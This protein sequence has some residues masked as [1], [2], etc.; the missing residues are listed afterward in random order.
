MLYPL[1]MLLIS[2]PSAYL[3]HACVNMVVPLKHLRLYSIAGTMGMFV[4]FLIRSYFFP[5]YSIFWELSTYLPTF[6]LLFFFTSPTQR[7]RAFLA[8]SMLL[9]TELFSMYLL[10]SVALPIAP[11]F[12]IAAERLTDPE[13]P[14]YLV[15]S[16]L[17]GIISSLSMYGCG[18]LLRQFLSPVKE[19]RSLMW[20][21]TIPLSQIIL[22]SLSTRLVITGSEF[23]GIPVS[24]VFGILLSVAADVACVLG[25]RKFRELEQLRA[26][27]QQAE[28]Q[29]NIQT[30]YYQEL[31]SNILTV[32]QI[33]HDLN[34][35]LQSAYYL[36]EHGQETEV[37]QQLNLLRGYI[38]DKVGTA[39]CE[40]LMVDA[41]LTEKARRCAD[42]G[43][44][45]EISVFAPSQLSIENAHLCSAFSNILDNGI[46]GTLEKGADAGPLQ[47][48]SDIHSGFFTIQCSNPAVK[49]K[50]DTNQDPLRSHGLG[51]EI[52]GQLA[53]HYHGH[54]Q[55]SFDN[56]RFTTTLILQLPPAGETLE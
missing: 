34:N 6:F 36:L 30:T 20:F 16:V 37:R 4:F 21:L 19:F 53:K 40:N 41:V 7:F 49:P 25:Y 48:Y 23:H 26:Q 39:Y 11:T 42:C 18:L 31:Q 24:M 55:T 51:L 38:Q 52:L 5:E 29:L 54:L 1:L 35:Q 15:M 3:C 45:L 46:H 27:V 50:K 2:F 28:Q 12:G 14:L 13:D 47:L 8:Q 17:L 44:S 9:L 33:R 43:I 32:N 22:I 56:D 10:A